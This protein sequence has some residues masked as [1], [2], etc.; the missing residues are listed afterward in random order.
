MVAS[1][2]L[3]ITAST[4]RCFPSSFPMS[5]LGSHT[6][7]PSTTR[8]G[9]LQWWSRADSS[10]GSGE[11]TE[12]AA[13]TCWTGS[14]SQPHKI[15]AE[16]ERGPIECGP[17]YLDPLTA[18]RAGPER[19]RRRPSSDAAVVKAAGAAAVRARGHPVPG[20]AGVDLVVVSD[21]AVTEQVMQERIERMVVRAGDVG[22]GAHHAGACGIESSP[23]HWR[24]LVV[25]G[26][27]K[28]NQRVRARG[29]RAP[30]KE[31]GPEDA[32]AKPERP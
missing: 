15:A 28:A 7:I 17:L 23:R 13:T 22:I 21:L 27:R 8:P 31:R 11:T 10:V 3:D 2:W 29:S 5:L 12:F 9:F 14:V 1:R 25:A 16:R 24:L 20:V 18:A 4:V 32:E 26:L 6:P 30:L 19:S